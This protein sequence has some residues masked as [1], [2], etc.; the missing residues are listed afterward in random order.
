MVL[1]SPPKSPAVAAAVSARGLAADGGDE[2]TTGEEEEEAVV[3]AFA[4]AVGAAAALF[5]TGLKRLMCKTSAPGSSASECSARTRSWPQRSHRR[6]SSCSGTRERVDDD[7]PTN[8]QQS[9]EH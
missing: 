9:G 6:F 3:L 2:M 8:A 7:T 4:L 1:V 5:I